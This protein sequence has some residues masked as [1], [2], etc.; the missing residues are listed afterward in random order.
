MY[1]LIR[2]ILV[3]SSVVIYFDRAK[4]VHDEYDMGYPEEL[5]E[6]LADAFKAQNSDKG[7][8]DGSNCSHPL[9]RRA[10]NFTSRE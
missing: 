10:P 4:H 2:K 3:S 7:L 9:P 8:R 6:T 1:E 5:V